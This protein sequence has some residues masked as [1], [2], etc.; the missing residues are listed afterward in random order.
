MSEGNRI[1]G[2]RTIQGTNELGQQIKKRRNE[3]GLTIEAAASK[4]G[5]GTKTWCRYEAGESIRQDKSKGICKALNWAFFPSQEAEKKKEDKF[6]IR[7]YKEHEAWSS[8]LETMFGELA[9]ISFVIGSDILLDHL[10][11]DIDALAAMPRG[12]HLGQLPVSFIVSDLP[13]QFLT[14]YDYDF[15]Y[16][17][18]CTVKKLRVQAHTGQEMQSHSV[19]EELA[20]YLIVE[21]AEFLMDSLEL[22]SKYENY[23]YWKDW[24]F[25][26]FDDV[27][28]EYELYSEFRLLEEKDKYHFVN[29]MK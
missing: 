29:W 11:E 14:R 8:Y 9:A 19:I 6:D 27:D 16:A 2:V 13:E 26:I 7:E 20:Y 17:L 5:V 21:E 10:N 28:I 12:T 25:E 18:R 4:A 23:E 24:I 15:V 1:M 3:L 22:E